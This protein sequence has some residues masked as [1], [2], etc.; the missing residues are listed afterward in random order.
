MSK[1]PR[2]HIEARDPDC[3]DHLQTAPEHK[4][5]LSYLLLFETNPHRHWHCAAVTWR[6]YKQQQKVTFYFHQPTI[7]DFQ[8]P[9]KKDVVKITG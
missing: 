2:P 6:E 8:K 4:Y 1:A 3:A 9:S 7:L 5:L